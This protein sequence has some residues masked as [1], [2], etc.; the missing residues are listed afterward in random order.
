MSSA[1]VVFGQTIKSS[2]DKDY[3]LSRLKYYEYKFGE[4]ENSD[5]LATDAVM[6]KKI[7]EAL[8]DELLANGYHPSSPGATDF[9][10]SF[11]VTAKDMVDTRSGV[12]RGPLG[13]RP[14]VRTQNY[15]QGTLVL[16]FIDAE[17][18]KLIWRGIAV[19]VVGTVTVDPKLA[20]E[21]IKKAAKLLLEQFRKDISGF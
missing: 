15:V 11:H 4:R 5:P 8:D 6:E 16:D 3:S 10:I 1:T 14:G 2:Y 17:T 12:V 21:R 19:G 9:L 20:E 18:K 13:P 7:Q